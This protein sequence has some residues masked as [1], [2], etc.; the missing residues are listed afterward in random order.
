MIKDKNA[1][2][3]NLKAGDLVMMKHG[4]MAVIT[5]VHRHDDM[6]HVDEPPPPPHIEMTYCDDGE[7][8]SC[9]SYRIER[10]L[11]ESR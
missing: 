3:H 2:R 5:S 8:G 11:S 1:W 6:W 10:M 4:G 9:S 7:H